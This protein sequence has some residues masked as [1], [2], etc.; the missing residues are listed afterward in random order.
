MTIN[1]DPC[2]IP[3][4]MRKL[5]DPCKTDRFESDAQGVLMVNSACTSTWEGSDLLQGQ[6]TG[7]WMVLKTRR[8]YHTYQLVSAGFLN[9]QQ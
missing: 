4:Q 7:V 6:A 9:H 8:L 3:P 1:F 5:N 2:V